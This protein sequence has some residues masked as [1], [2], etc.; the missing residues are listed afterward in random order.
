MLQRPRLLKPSTQTLSTLAAAPLPRDASCR[1]NQPHR[2]TARRG[3]R[4]RSLLPVQTG[5]RRAA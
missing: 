5:A 2:F 4:A 3:Q 1:T